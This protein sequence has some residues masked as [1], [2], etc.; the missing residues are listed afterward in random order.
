MLV[1]TITRSGDAD[2]DRARMRRL[3]GYLTQF[4]GHDRFCFIVV[5]GNR[6]PARLDYPRH[7]IGIND[8]SLAYARGLLGDENVVIEDVDE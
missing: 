3:H 6:A 5:G 8:D 1:L 4:P 7:R 2:R